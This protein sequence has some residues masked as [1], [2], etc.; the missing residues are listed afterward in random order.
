MKG[1]HD[2]H[3]R[4][5]VL[6]CIWALIVDISPIY[7]QTKGAVQPLF[8]LSTKAPMQ[9]RI[10]RRIDLRDKINQPFHQSAN[11][12]LVS[13]QY[14]YQKGLLHAL[15]SGLYQQRIP[16]YDPHD[17]SYALTPDELRYRICQCNPTAGNNPRPGMVELI[18]PDT[19]WTIDQLMEQVPPYFD[20]VE[21]HWVDGQNNQHHHRIQSI[22][23]YHHYTPQLDMPLLA[24]DY[25]EACA[26]ILAQTRWFNRWNDAQEKSAAQALDL[27]LYNGTVLKLNAQPAK[28]IS[29]A[30]Q[31]DEDRI[32]RLQQ[33]QTH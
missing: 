1:L 16:A 21:Y 15:I 10:V 9:Q 18:E 32:Q 4:Y 6:T 33:L 12:M 24:I 20:I 5:W 3:L 26:P 23:L 11:G 2:F 29:E 22:I 25:E 8:A 17:L 31:M 27:R 14:R 30:Q 13:Q 19:S 28:S 7:G